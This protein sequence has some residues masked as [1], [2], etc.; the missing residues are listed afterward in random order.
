M[1]F[2]VVGLIV[3]LFLFPS[4]TVINSS[5]AD[6]DQTFFSAI[7]EAFSHNG[8]VLLVLGFLFAV[9]K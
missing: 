8:Y 1:I 5:Q 4:K 2:I 9:F 3:S 7:K 6:R